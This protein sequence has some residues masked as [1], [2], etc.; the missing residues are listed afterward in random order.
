VWKH[1]CNKQYA[2]SY[3]GIRYYSRGLV[4]ALH[5]FKLRVSVPAYECTRNAVIALDFTND[6]KE[7]GR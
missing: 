6:C 5:I 4:Y 7:T 2:L 1:I 3:S